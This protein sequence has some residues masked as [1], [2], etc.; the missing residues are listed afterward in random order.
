MH[1]LAV[2]HIPVLCG[3]GAT[4]SWI[5]PTSLL[6]SPFFLPFFRHFLASYTLV[7]FGLASAVSYWLRAYARVAGCDS[8]VAVGSQGFFAGVACFLCVDALCD[9]VVLPPQCHA[10]VEH[11]LELLVMACYGSEGAFGQ[12]SCA[13]TRLCQAPSWSH[14]F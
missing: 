4:Q 1:R 10:G 9:L 6:F 2:G 11:M 8:G 5:S 3:P 14:G 12:Y 7:S 13:L